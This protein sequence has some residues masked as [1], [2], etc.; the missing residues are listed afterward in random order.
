MLRLLLRLLLGFK[1][2]RDMHCFCPFPFPVFFEFLFYFWDASPKVCR[3]FNPNCNTLFNPSASHTEHTDCHSNHCVLYTNEHRAATNVEEEN[4]G[5]KFYLLT[6][7][8]MYS[9][10]VEKQHVVSSKPWPRCIS[11]YVYVHKISF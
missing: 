11:N 5:N 8:I 6:G 4:W 9:E 1:N 3:I 7:K 10:D 2:G